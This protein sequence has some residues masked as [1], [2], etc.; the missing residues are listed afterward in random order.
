MS[1]LMTSDHLDLSYLS[2]VFIDWQLFLILILILIVAQP[3]TVPDWRSNWHSSCIAIVVEIGILV[4]LHCN[5][6]AIVV[7]LQFLLH[8]TA[9]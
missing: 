2:P 9:L 8:C 7:A 6:I 4:A 1:L 5:C 3:D